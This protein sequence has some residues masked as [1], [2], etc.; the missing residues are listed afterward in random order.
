[1]IGYN[2]VAMV[3]A[4]IR[5]TKVHIRVLDVGWFMKTGITQESKSI[6]RQARHVFAFQRLCVHVSCV[7]VWLCVVVCVFVCVFVDSHAVSMERTRVFIVGLVI[8]RCEHFVLF[9]A[10]PPVHIQRIRSWVHT[11]HVCV[12]VCACVSVS[13]CGRVC[14]I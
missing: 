14:V 3:L 7:C 6:A 1:M 13:V 12:C 2:V 9:A 8:P 11:I 10:S 4:K 5:R